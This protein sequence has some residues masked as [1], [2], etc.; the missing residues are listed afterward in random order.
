[1]KQEKKLTSREQPQTSQTQSHQT[2]VREFQTAEEL[3]RY[4]A[5]QTPVPPAVARRLDESIQREP[6]AAR[7]W[8]RRLTGG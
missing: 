6:K 4:D 5:G 3:L 8:W 7:P 2:E 1:M